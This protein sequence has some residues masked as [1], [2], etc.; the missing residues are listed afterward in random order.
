MTLAAL[1]AEARA[2]HLR[3]LAGFHPRA[4]DGDLP[5]G[6]GTVLMLSPDEPAFWPAFTRSPEYR[7]GAAD[8]MDRWSARVIGGWAARL[9]ATPLY[10]FGGPPFRPF[11]R[12]ALDSGAVHQSPV[13]LLVH[14]RAGLFVSFRGA[15]ALPERLELPVPAPSPCAGCVTRPCLT[16]CPVGALTAHG[17][18]VPACKAHVTGAGRK[19]CLEQGCGVRLSCPASQGHGRVP[20]QSAFHMQNFI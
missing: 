7:D 1:E 16:A 17:Y 11:I 12:W 18:D 5:P 15:L 14:A 2:L 8:P 19:T 13:G 10:P 20:E 6:T 4:G 9:G 3:V